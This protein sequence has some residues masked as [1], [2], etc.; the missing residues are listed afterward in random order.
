MRRNLHGIKIFK[1]RKDTPTCQTTNWTKLITISSRRSQNKLQTKI[2]S[3]QDFR[4]EAK[5]I[6]LDF[7]QFH[8]Q[9]YREQRY[10]L[11]MLKN[12]L[13]D[14]LYIGISKN[15]IWERWFG[16]GGH[17]MWDGEVKKKWNLSEK[18][19]NYI[20]KFSTTRNDLCF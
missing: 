13:G 8:D 16:W 6:E 15:D 3:A 12:G 20:E 19:M 10:E 1:S 9:Q 2:T 11:Y 4:P 18:R 17:M 7:Q 5:M 14:I